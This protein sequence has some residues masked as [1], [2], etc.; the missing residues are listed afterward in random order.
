MVPEDPQ[1]GEEQVQG[2]SEGEEVQ[3]AAHEE[4]EE[5]ERVVVGEAAVQEDEDGGNQ[6]STVLDWLS[7]KK[8]LFHLFI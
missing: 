6:Y 2:V 7:K 3:E 5:V 8:G 4:E 1:G